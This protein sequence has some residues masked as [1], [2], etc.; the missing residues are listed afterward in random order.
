VLID[1]SHNA[2]L[3]ARAQRLALEAVDAVVKTPL[4][5]VRIHLMS[6]PSACIHKRIDKKQHSATVE[7]GSHVHKLLHLLLLHAVLELALLGGR[8]TAIRLAT[9]AV[10]TEGG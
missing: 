4:D 5:E 2:A 3:L 6:H 9:R 1:T 10:G 7:G 8:K